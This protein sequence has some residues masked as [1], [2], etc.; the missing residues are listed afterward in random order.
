MV[1][2]YTTAAGRRITVGENPAEN[3]QLVQNASPDDMWFH[4]STKEHDSPHAILAACGTPGEGEE[5]DRLADQ[6]GAIADAAQ[7]VKHHSK[8]S[9]RYA[10]K[11]RVC[12]LPVA[13]V[14]KHSSGNLGTVRLLAPPQLLTVRNDQTA[15]SRLRATQTGAPT[16]PPEPVQRA[17]PRR[18]NT[19]LKARTAKAA[20]HQG[21]ASREVVDNSLVAPSLDVLDL[22]AAEPMELYEILPSMWPEL[23]DTDFGSPLIALASLECPEPEPERRPNAEEEGEPDCL[24]PREPVGPP[25]SAMADM[26]NN[27]GVFEGPTSPRALP[28]SPPPYSPPSPRRPALLVSNQGDVFRVTD[29]SSSPAIVEFLEAELRAQSRAPGGPPSTPRVMLPFSSESVRKAAAMLEQAAAG[30]MLDALPL[31]L[32][33]GGKRKRDSVS[34]VTLADQAIQLLPA[35]KREVRGLATAQT[36]EVPVLNP[37]YRP[38]EEVKRRLAAHGGALARVMS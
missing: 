5:R 25:P 15:I 3:D 12:Y 31:Q 28:A 10:A 1:L 29:A 9:S 38:P 32:A 22:D 21:G 19:A 11:T 4:L 2:C 17:T 35:P 33:H 36:R 7:L 6:A 27:S 20:A 37:L 14:E 30:G 34:P 8:A 13:N 16:Q 26:R 18:N 24:T 23:A